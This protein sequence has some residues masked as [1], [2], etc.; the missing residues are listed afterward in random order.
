MTPHFSTPSW[1]NRIR[2][3]FDGAT[4]LPDQPLWLADRL[5]HPTSDERAGADGARAERPERHHVYVPENYEANYPYPL[6]VWL[7]DPGHSVPDL[8][9][10]FPRISTQ[11]FVATALSGCG[12]LESLFCTLT[13]LTNLPVEETAERI[14]DRVRQIRR[15]YHIHTERV[16]VAGCDLAAS[17]ALE[18]L[19]QKPDWFAGMLGFGRVEVPR[20]RSLRHFRRLRG[21]RVFIGADLRQPRKA[22]ATFLRTGRLLHSAGLDVSA[23]L[24]DADAPVTSEML[25]DVNHW[26]IQGICASNPV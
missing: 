17:L 15:C 6:I 22:L 26:L 24:Y 4:A 18:L 3:A 8:M 11:N 12:L 19:L 20:G 14:L 16:Y 23:R 5:T 9:R 13:G 1:P 10:L 21:K 25:S 7:T 2:T